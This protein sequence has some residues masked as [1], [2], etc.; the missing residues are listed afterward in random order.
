MMKSTS[1]PSISPAEFRQRLLSDYGYATDRVHPVPVPV[2]PS[3]RYHR[4]V[5]R[6]V[7]QGARLARRGVYDS[8]AW[9][10]SSATIL[11]AVETLGGRIVIEGLD[12]LAALDGPFVIA[13]NHMSA[14]ETQALACI[15]LPFSKVTFVVK[16]SLL[17]YPLFGAIL[18][19]FDPI[20]LTRSDPRADLKTLL[21]EGVRRLSDGTS[22]I[23]FP[24]AKRRA[25]FDPATFNSI[26]CKLAGRAGVPVV[27]LALKTDFLARGFPVPD[28]GRVNP[29]KDVH[30]RFGPPIQAQSREKQAHRE[31]V[32]FIGD[33][34]RSLGAPIVSSDSVSRK[35]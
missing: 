19:C 11:L 9:A 4:I 30:F 18:R 7:W 32:A 33:H 28:F 15:L 29:R 35:P 27:P 21:T 8:D 25:V 13:A 31:T 10:E 26:A 14:L 22:L 3:L 12:S 24:Q 2:F 34:L 5:F 23:L 16:R 1:Y 6:C 17:Y 20:A